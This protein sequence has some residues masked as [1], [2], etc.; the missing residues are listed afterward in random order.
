MK[1]EICQT[2]EAHFHFATV[3]M[4]EGKEV[5]LCFGCAERQGLLFADLRSAVQSILD[6]QGLSLEEMMKAPEPRKASVATEPRRKRLTIDD[7][8]NAQGD[9]RQGIPSTCPA[10]SPV[11]DEADFK[12]R[13]KS[14]NRRMQ[15]AIEKEDY[16]LCARLR[17]EISSVKRNFRK[18][19]GSGKEKENDG[20]GTNSC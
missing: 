16:E 7:F 11:D 19:K 14:L 18:H 8:L 15:T 2:E 4:F 9:S 17:D 10:Y 12:R 5:H 1:C 6:D 20:S 13:I 3:D